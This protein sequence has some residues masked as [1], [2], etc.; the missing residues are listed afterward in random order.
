MLELNPSAFGLH[1]EINTNFSKKICRESLSVFTVLPVNGDR[2]CKNV[3]SSHSRVRM[4]C[5]FIKRTYLTNH[6]MCDSI[7]ICNFVSVQVKT[8]TYKMYMSM[9]MYKMLL[10]S[11]RYD[12]VKE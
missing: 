10:N 1:T 8:N 11:F 12:V 3:G 4:N 7:V 6:R 2:S 5:V 9:F